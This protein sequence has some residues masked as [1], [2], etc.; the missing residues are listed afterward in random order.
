MHSQVPVFDP[1]EP[2]SFTFRWVLFPGRHHL[3]THFQEEYITDVFAGRCVTLSGLVAEPAPAAELVVPVTSAD[4]Q[5]TRRNPV[6]YHRREAQLTLFAHS[7]SVPLRVYPIDD[8][9]PSPRFASH[10]ISAIETA[11]QGAVLLDPSNTLVACSTPSVFELYRALGFEVVTVE[12]SGYGTDDEQYIPTLP[13]QLVEAIAEGGEA[14]ASAWE[15]MAAASRLIWDRYG[16]AERVTEIFSDPLLT[17]DGDITPHR[18]YAPYT[19][20][21]DAGAARKWELLS[22]LVRPG[23]IVDVGCGGGALLARA[24]ADPALADSDL[25]GI[26]VARPLYEECVHRR[27]MGAFANPNTFFYQA[28]IMARPLFA[29]NSVDTTLTV[30]LTHEIFSYSQSPDPNDDLTLLASQIFT[31][32]APGGVWLNLDVAGPDDPDREVILWLRDAV[33]DVPSPISFADWE[34]DMAAVGSDDTKEVLDAMSPAARFRCFVR[35]FRPHL[36][37]PAFRRLPPSSARPPEA[38]SPLIPVLTSARVAAEFL[39]HW[40]YTDSWHSEMQEAFTYM[41]FPRWRELLSRAGFVVD[42]ESGPFTNPWVVE[43]LYRGAGVVTD[44]NSQPVP[45]FATNVLIVARKL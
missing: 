40:T 7:L 27:S 21:Q 28:N 20:S 18:D 11:S 36:P 5:N 45:P 1:S 29:P 31:H 23:R 4:H 34:P 6:P 42:A 32:T 30:S 25:Y 2:P 41:P 10:T 3:L 24:A 14:A 15:E 35:D 39:S 16:L 12:L 43:N 37:R 17:D 26:E 8:V 38:G 33:P 13:F 44:S 22:P 9:P 19:A